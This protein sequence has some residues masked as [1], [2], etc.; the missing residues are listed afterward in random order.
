MPGIS[1]ADSVQ[2]K[3]PN[4][5]PDVLGV[6]SGDLATISFSNLGSGGKKCLFKACFAVAVHRLAAQV[7]SILPSLL[8][9]DSPMKNISERE[10]VEQF[11]GF[12][13]MLHELSQ[14]ELRDSQFILIDKELIQPV[15][16]YTRVFSARH[17][18]PY[19]PANP[20]PT[21]P[22]LISYYQGK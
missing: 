21:N 17:M 22:P 20:D 15:D 1:D 8:V 3:S 4:F 2:I 18:K 6:K 19:D 13:R 14:G 12:H 5:L 7:G 9:I 10:N 16:K 11:E